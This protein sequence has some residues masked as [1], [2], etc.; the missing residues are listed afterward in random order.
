MQAKASW[1]NLFIRHLVTGAAAVAFG[2]IACTAVA[3]Q[4]AEQGS[5]RIQ[6]DLPKGDLARSLNALGRKAGVQIAFQP[7]R[8]KGRRAKALRGHFSFEEALARLLEGTGLQFR[9]TQGGSY[10]ITGPTLTD[11]KKIRESGQDLKASRGLDSDGNAAVAEILVVGSKSWTLNLDIP[12]TADD[13][14]PYVV[15]SREQ[16]ERSGSTSL[17]DFFRNFLGANTTG[18]NSTQVPR[19]DGQSAI[20]LRG[21]GVE[22]TLVLVD[23]RRTASANLGGGTFIQSSINGIPIDAIE[24]IEVLASSASGIYGSNAVGGVVNIIMRRDYRGIQATAFYGDTS[25]FDAAQKRLSLNGSFPLEKGRTRLSFSASWQKTGGLYEGERDFVTRG[26]AQLFENAPTYYNSLQQPLI[27][28][29]PNIVSSTGANLVLKPQ[30]GGTS[31]G[32]RV[33]YVPA[34][35]RGIAQ[36]G[37]G[38]LIANAGKQNLEI[39]QLPVSGPGGNGGLVKLIRPTQN[40]NASA[41]LRRDFTDWLN[42]YGEFSFSRYES[43]DVESPAAGYYSL[44]ANNPNNPFTRAINVFVP[45]EDGIVTKKSVSINKQLVVG[46]IVKLP[47]DWSA[48]IDLTWG[49]G[50]AK[51]PEEL[52]AFDAATVAGLTNGTINLLRDV[53]IDP[54]QLGYLDTPA[55]GLVRRPPSFSRSYAIKLAGPMPLLRLWGGKPIISVNLDRTRQAYGEYVSFQNSTTLSNITWTPSRSLRTDGVYGEVRFPIVSKDNNVPFIRELELQ[56]AARYDRYKGVGANADLVCFSIL[57][58]LPPEAFDLPCPQGQGRPDP[59]FVETDDHAFSPTIALKWAVAEDIAFR[60]SYSRGFAPVQLNNVVSE[61]RP[62]FISSTDPL[63]GHE[64]IGE[65]FLNLG[66]LYRLPIHTGGNPNVDP[67]KSESW[68]FGAILTPHWVPGLRLS[69]DWSKITMRNLYFQPEILLFGGP[70]GGYQ[71]AFEDFLAIFPERFVRSTDPSTFGP[72]SVG[73]IISADVSTANLLKRDAEAVDFAVNYDTSFLGGNLSL[74]GQATWIRSLKIQTFFGT[75]TEELAG[76]IGNDFL[77]SLS[78]NGS[79]RWKGNAQAVYSADK[80]SLGL[81]GRYFD[82]YWLRSDHAVVPEQ[83]GAKIRSQIYFDLFGSYQITPKT[84]I[85]AV[86]N[87]VFDR[88]P[89]INSSMPQFYSYQGDPRRANFNL[90]LVQKF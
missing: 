50:H 5:S 6:I 84:E 40:F 73:P 78:G 45:I 8:V 58:P 31:L 37:V 20:N 18:A 53:S 41:T 15:F 42:L 77:S 34:S 9:K 24:R 7:D 39:A 75:P 17:E 16:I 22:N 43:N 12:R 55:S 79:L 89:P 76:V 83:G 1:R 51:R 14:Q 48:A 33:T 56:V 32:S 60:G 71:D 46:G 87:N 26:R 19:N 38:A 69:V 64:R 88:S 61:D 66:F 68:S 27:G 35:F 49:W 81:R 63:R 23:G 70:T 2:S 90:T 57:A 11:I 62:T 67:Q 47:Y 86:L 36:D 52:P 28:T 80:W 25:R 4:E 10:V 72:Y 59:I 74:Y 3:A 29:T 85:R 13:A 21:L 65:N 82:S 44:A 54:P 30:Y